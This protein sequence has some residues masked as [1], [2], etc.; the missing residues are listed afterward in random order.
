MRHVYAKGRYFDPL[1]HQIT[2]NPEISGQ[3]TAVKATFISLPI[4]C[5]MPG[6]ETSE[7]KR[8]EYGFVREQLQKIFENLHFVAHE[9]H[10]ARNRHR[11]LASKEF[12]KRNDHPIRSLMEYAN[13]LALDR[14]RDEQQATLRLGD[15]EGPNPPFIHVPEF[16]ALIINNCK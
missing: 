6:Q 16:W 14:S 2:A 12:R 11:Q 15:A 10:Y 3:K 8:D 9:E 5:S 1:V 4:F 7:D 13:I